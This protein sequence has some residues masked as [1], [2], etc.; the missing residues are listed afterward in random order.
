[1]SRARLGLLVGATV[2]GLSRVLLLPDG[3]WEQD[4]AIFASA[5]LDY[6]VVRHRPQPPGF[7]GWIALG[8][9]A[10]PLV[11]DP[12]LAL[13]LLSCIASVATF[14]LLAVL[15]RRVVPLTLAF[16][17]ATLH[18]FTP[19]VWFHAPRAFADTPAV[20]LAL[21]AIAAWSSARPRIVALGWVASF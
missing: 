13:R 2:V 10:H 21:A 19:T 4:E 5:V 11:R 14:V 1:M 3:P 17:A 20:A 9:L 18:A 6:D 16:A 15:L 7:P 12:L 8:K